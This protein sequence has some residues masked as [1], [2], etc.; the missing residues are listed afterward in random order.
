MDHP[1]PDKRYAHGE[2]QSCGSILPATGRRR[3]SD[4]IAKRR[5]LGWRQIVNHRRTAS[6]TTENNMLLTIIHP[7]A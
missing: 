6:M 3:Q 2:R 1:A 5:R 7:S 4:H